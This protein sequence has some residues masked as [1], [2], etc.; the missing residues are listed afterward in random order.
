[1]TTVIIKSNS[2]KKTQLLIQLAEELGLDAQT[3]DFKELDVKAMAQGIGRKATDEE[4][5]DYLSKGLDEKPVKLADALKR[6]S[7]TK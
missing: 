3:Q 6:Y 4:L 7:T 5:L 2:D 1:M